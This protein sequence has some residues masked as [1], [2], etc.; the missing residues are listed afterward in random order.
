[1]IMNKRFSTLLAAALVAGGLSANVMAADIVTTDLKDGQFIHLSTATGG[2]TYLTMDAK[3]DFS[4][5]VASSWSGNIDKLLGSLWQVKL[6]PHTTQAGTTYTYSLTNRLSGQLLSVKLQSDVDGG[7]RSENITANEK[8]GNTEWAYASGNALYAIKGDTVFTIGIGSNV[9]TFG[10]TEDTSAPSNTSLYMGAVS[11]AAVTLKASDFNALVKANAGRLFF[12]D[13]NVSST[14]KNV[15]TANKWEAVDAKMTDG[16]YASGGTDVLFLTNGKEYKNRMNNAMTAADQTQKEYLLVDYNFYDPSK[17]FNVLKADTIA[18][19]P[20][21]DAVSNFDK[22]TVIAKH[23]PATAAF[24][25]TYYIP[26]DS[27]VIAPAYVQTSIPVATTLKA[28]HTALP[29]N[30]KVTAVETAVN[31]LE[32]AVASF[33]TTYDGTPTSMPAKGDKFAEADFATTGG[34]W[35]ASSSE[36][37]I[38]GE[39]LIEA[40]KTAIKGITYS[41]TAATEKLEKA[42]VAKVNAYLSALNGLEIA[43]LAT[44]GGQA[45]NYAKVSTSAIKDGAN[46]ADGLN[47]L[48]VNAVTSKQVVI[49]KLSNTKVLTIGGDPAVVANGNLVATIKTSDKDATIGGDATIAEGLYYVIDAMKEDDGA[50]NKYYG[51]YFDES[52]VNAANYVAKAQ[53]FNPYAQFVVTKAA[54][55]DKGNYAIENRATANAK[56]QGVTNVV[57]KDNKI[58]TIGNDT[59]QL[60]AADDVDEDNAYIGFKYITANDAKNNKFTITSAAEMLAGQTIVMVKDSSLKIAEGEMLFTLTPS[61]ETEYGVNEDLINVSYTIYNDADSTYLVKDDASDNYRFIHE[62]N[63]APSAITKF[64]MIA[65][66]TD[67]TYV[68]ADGLDDATKMVISTQ[69]K[70]ISAKDLDERNDMFIVKPQAAPASYKSL[71]KHVRIQAINGDYAAVNAKNQ[72]IAVREGD[73]KADAYDNLDFIFWLDTAH[74][75]NAAPYTYYITKGVKETEEVA[76]SRLYM[77]NSYDSAKVKDANKEL[78]YV[79]GAGANRVMFRTASIMAQ[80]TLLVPTMDAAAK[81]DTVSIAAKPAGSA[82]GLKHNV[83]AGVKN[84]QFS[85]EFASKDADNEYNIVCQNNNGKNYVHNINGVLAMGPKEDAV[86][87][88]VLNVTPE[89]EA[90]TGNETINAEGVKVIAANGGVQIIG[91]QGKKVVITNILGQTVANTVLSSDNATIAAPQGVVVVAIEGEE[92][93]KAIVK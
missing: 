35:Q 54:G 10:A 48:T 6:I 32:A 30:G 38:T 58:Y 78:P 26:N 52:P 51:L 55:V 72:G 39:E 44:T 90:A 37:T 11:T 1:M 45:A 23:H 69:Y 8:G 41:T 81:I 62:S 42:Y 79:Y 7:G 40:V 93:V 59:I 87:V 3:G 82:D 84:F 53:A 19:E 4:T 21:S 86:V 9:L 14:E 29:T 28:M 73:L 36:S 20:T 33:Y 47:S 46:Y 76:A 65:V 80:D 5:V 67:S 92:A 18:V 91:A 70:T 64:Y 12:T 61:E 34:A 24:T 22:R 56:W 83:K 27:M 88:N 15:L 77:W 85:F 66:D 74:Y 63:I 68:L 31:A 25:V 16:A 89:D 60:V 17:E 43:D 2:T 75:E 57:D 13:E 71:P 49:R 50:E